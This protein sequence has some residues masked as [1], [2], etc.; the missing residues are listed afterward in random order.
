MI[1]EKQ[2]DLRQSKEQDRQLYW[3]AIMAE[4]HLEKWE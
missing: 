1:N 3:Q 2:Q 4:K